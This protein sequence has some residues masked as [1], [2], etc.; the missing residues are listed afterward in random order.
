MRFYLFLVLM[1]LFDTAAVVVA[2]YYVEKKKIWILWGSLFSF[3]ASAYFFVR[4]MEFR[5]TAI[6]N[7][8]AAALS[9]IVATFIFYVAFKERITKGQW[10][11]VVI[12]FLG[13][14]MLEFP[15]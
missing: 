2:R 4:M 11:G 13:I 15:L 8:L 14:L 1:G 6:V 7:V 10:V 5:M 9:T 12:A 3:A